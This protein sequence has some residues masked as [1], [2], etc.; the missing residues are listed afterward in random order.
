MN[1][2]KA[3]AAQLDDYVIDLAWS[4]GGR[5]LAAASAAGPVNLLD[6]ATGAKLHELS[7]HADGTNALAFAPAGQMPEVSGQRAEVRG[8]W[9]EIK[10][11]RSEA[12]GLT[13][14]VRPLASGLL[15]SG[16][17][18]GKVRFWNAETGHQMAETDTVRKAW[19]EHLEWQPHG[20]KF[21]IPS[22][23]SQ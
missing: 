18:D 16:G 8:Q 7:G 10:G 14:D 23:K 11:Q 4:P 3:W 1:V 5:L 13:S 9:S 19:V 15:A 20:R 2:T 12:S 21:Q 17:Q 6:G 22:S